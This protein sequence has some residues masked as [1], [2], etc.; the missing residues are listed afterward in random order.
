MAAALLSAAMV[1]VLIA[2]AQQGQAA[3]G[4]GA[5]ETGDWFADTH[6]DPLDFSNPEDV[7][8]VGEGPMQGFTNQTLTGG[9][10]SMNVAGPAYFSPLWPSYEGSVPQRRE[11]QAQSIDGRIYR[12]VEVR[13]QSSTDLSASVFA[14]TCSSGINDGCLSNIATLKLVPNQWTS[15]VGE[16]PSTDVTGLRVAV[17]GAGSLLVDYVTVGAGVGDSPQPEVLNPDQAGAVPRLFPARERA[18]AYP[19]LPEGSSLGVCANNDWATVVRTN[20]WD[21]SESLATQADS[22]APPGPYDVAQTDN[23]Q[24]WSIEK[25]WFDGIGKNGVDGQKPGDPGIRLSLVGAAPKGKKPAATAIAAD[26]FHRLTVEVPKW[27]GNYSQQF[28]GNGGWVLRAVWKNALS[29][30]AFNVSLPIVEYPNLF[31]ITVDMKDTNSFDQLPD[32]GKGPV[33]PALQRWTGLVNLFRIDLAEPYRDRHTFMDQVWLATDDCADPKYGADILFRDNAP[34]AGTNAT[35]LARQSAN[36]PWREIGKMPVSG[37][38]IQRFRW[39]DVPAGSWFIKVTMTRGGASRSAVSTGPVT[40]AAALLGAAPRPAADP[41]TVPPTP[42]PPTTVPPTTVPV[43]VKRQP[44]AGLTITPA[45]IDFGAVLVGATS[46]KKTFKV[47]NTGGLPLTLVAKTISGAAAA[48]YKSP[49]NTCGIPVLVPKASCTIDVI[50]KPTAP[51]ARIAKLT[52]AAAAGRTRLSATGGIRATPPVPP[53]TPKA[54]VPPVTIPAT[55]APPV[56]VPPSTA[57][58]IVKVTPSLRMDPAVGVGGQVTTVI[59][60]G[61]PANTTVELAWAGFDE[62]ITVRTDEFGAFRYPVLLLPGER[63]GAQTIQVLAQPTFDA[64][65]ARF[66]LQFPTFAP[67]SGTRR[68]VGRN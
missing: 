32:R 1:A 47:T 28:G 45:S 52:V 22:K 68:F 6:N 23:Y 46:A 5:G 40:N 29:T 12:R 3:V 24:R 33:E 54:T 62:I 27:D 50:V 31:T 63:I 55:T 17:D 20:P 41:T 16:L 60:Q 49:S 35:L 44:I 57:P 51:G 42:A 26:L 65:S 58:P 43:V 13:L 53:T 8:L 9:I 61:F 67:R 48:D 56:T 66:L 64:V 10:L 59:G 36:D 14:S 34:A 2:P 11:G 7:A 25:G 15:L 30:P 21:F 37:G 19:P 4:I 38:G 39:T 18:I